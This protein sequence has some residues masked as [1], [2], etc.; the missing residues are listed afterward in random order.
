MHVVRYLLVEPSVPFRT[1]E[2]MQ[3]VARG[4]IS[5]NTRST[6]SAAVAPPP[7]TRTGSSTS[8]SSEHNVRVSGCLAPS[9]D[10]RVRIQTP[11]L[12]QRPDHR[13][14][15]V[16]LTAEQLGGSAPRTE[17]RREIGLGQAAIVH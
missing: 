14:G 1:F 15:K 3:R 12:D 11:L 4:A 2:A 5:G 13:F 6:R 16:A 8:A 7:L 9:A 10:Q 17:E